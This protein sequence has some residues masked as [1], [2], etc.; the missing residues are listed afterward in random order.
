[1]FATTL[2]LC[3]YALLVWRQYQIENSEWPASRALRN[4]T[5]ETSSLPISDALVNT[6]WHDL[7]AICRTPHSYN[8]VQHAY[9][10]EYLL[11][12]VR[13]TI[14]EAP[15]GASEY[16]ELIDA[17]EGSI[18][19][20][21]FH[22]VD[23]VYF[24]S[25][26]I[27]A[28]VKGTTDV[29][30]V[31]LTGHYDSVST[32]YGTTD[33]GISIVT[34]LALF[35]YYSTHRPA[36]TIL[37]HFDTGE[38]LGMLGSSAFVQHSAMNFV[39]YFVNLEGAGAGGRAALFRGSNY[40]ALRAFGKLDD[41]VGNVMMQDAFHLG[42]VQS[43]TDYQCYDEAGLRGLDI[44]FYKP[45]ARY[46][47]PYDSIK[48]T[49]RGALRYMLESAASLASFLSSE[50]PELVTEENKEV[51]GVFFDVFERFQ[52]VVPLPI[53]AKI[54]LALI[55]AGPVVVLLLLLYFAYVKSVKLQWSC[56]LRFPAVIL[57]LLAT[58]AGL[59]YLFAKLNPDIIY[60]SDMPTFAIL[61]TCLF[62]TCASL[63]VAHSLSPSQSELSMMFEVAFWFWLMGAGSVYL[64]FNAEIGG[65]YVIIVQYTGSTIAL[66][67][68]LLTSAA[69]AE[70]NTPK[71]KKKT[72]GATVKAKQ[73]RS[74]ITE[75]T[76][77]MSKKVKQTQ[78]G[79]KL[80]FN[81]VS[82]TALRFAEIL[83]G[84]LV[85][86]VLLLPVMFFTVNALRYG[87]ADGSNGLL[88]YGVVSIIS[89]SLLLALA[90]YIAY[91]IRHRIFLSFSVYFIT[92]VVVVSLIATSLTTFPFTEQVPLKVYVEQTINLT[93]ANTG[94]W[95]EGGEMN[96][97]GLT[98]YMP[99]L[100]DDIP[101]AN[102]F[103]CV[104]FGKRGTLSRCSYP[105]LPPRP[106]A[107]ASSMP[108]STWLNAAAH[109]DSPSSF[110]ISIHSA[111][112]RG[113]EL[114]ISSDAYTD[115]IPALSF[116]VVASP[117]FADVVAGDHS[118]SEYIANLTRFEFW[119]RCDLASPTA[120]NGTA[121]FKI[122]ISAPDGSTLDDTLVTHLT[123]TAYY[124]EWI[125][126]VGTFFPSAAS[127]NASVSV[128][129]TDRSFADG[130]LGV[131][132]AF[133]ELLQ[134]LPKWATFQ[135]RDSGIVRVSKNVRLVS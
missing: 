21:H 29:P 107:A 93:D 67:C 89:T 37:F 127:R 15:A 9:V 116:D 102:N 94:T 16:I 5:G 49:H 87:A 32:S 92:L 26:N 99:L 114:V 134:Y 39:N 10:R 38:E 131:L 132:P 124:D 66:V 40:E 41:S 122:R 125:P 23:R 47:S 3:L 96:L 30:G 91:L 44:A 34:L 31:M 106:F 119:S 82:L 84:V 54:S 133:D 25:E 28:I 83:F 4:I 123:A 14:A 104:P 70:Q 33:D 126:R 69:S 59:T 58:N 13:Q 20:M 97:V 111:F 135:K 42:L 64:L 24:E 65:S 130:E 11:Q 51:L 85:P 61:V 22:H 1:M 62:I 12:R 35:R 105:A 88:A 118:A 108:S 60:S 129:K 52:V 121:P 48:S 53:F 68:A 128:A 115:T 6:A 95:R 117:Y 36:R 90:P 98:E 79:K 19:V 103:T 80:G 17:S 7:Q 43:A 57:A 63:H 77:L 100:L 74:K 45:R 72:R 76:T 110:V 112:S 113:G 81:T 56:W 46:H 18:S 75:K 101:T 27:Y 50:E 73:A 8:S 78:I 120:C 55:I 109:R 71:R 86:A 2:G